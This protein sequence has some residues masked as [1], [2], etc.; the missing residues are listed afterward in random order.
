MVG[1]SLSFSCAGRVGRS[2]PLPHRATSPF[3]SIPSPTQLTHPPP[4]FTGV[5]TLLAGRVPARQMGIFKGLAFKPYEL[6]KTQ[7]VRG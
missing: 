3:H 2:L 6:P 1:L 5:S 4:V 7:K